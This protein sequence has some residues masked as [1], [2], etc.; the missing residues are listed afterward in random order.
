MKGR[1]RGTITGGYVRKT[2]SLPK[3]LVE[4]IESNLA[5]GVTISVFMTEAGE[6]LLAKRARK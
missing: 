1:A 3:A 5:P 6:L 2:L 4:E